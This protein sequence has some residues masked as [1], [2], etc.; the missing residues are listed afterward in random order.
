MLRGLP[1]RTAYC[2]G[3][4]AA[5]AAHA[6]HVA[7][8]L[9]VNAVGPGHVAMGAATGVSSRVDHLGVVSNAEQV[10]GAPT[11]PNGAHCADSDLAVRCERA[12]VLAAPPRVWFYCANTLSAPPKRDP[13]VVALSAGATLL[14]PIDARVAQ[15]GE[16]GQDDE[17]EGLG[18]MS[19]RCAAA[20]RRVKISLVYLASFQHMGIAHVAC[21][22]GCACE[23]TTIDAHRPPVA[24]ERGISVHLTHSFPAVGAVEGCVV[25]VE[26]GTNSS[27][28]GHKFKLLQASVQPLGVRHS[29]GSRSCVQ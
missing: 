23:R 15:P 10:E 18:G 28:G 21:R 14:L 16:D 20:R 26:V 24:D 25:S 5:A 7:L 13:G 19:D 9:A 4:D 8:A 27:S 11:A 1:W 22:A 6:V 3:S 12:N 2:N 17:T 29:G